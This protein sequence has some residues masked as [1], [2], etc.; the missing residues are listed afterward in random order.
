MDREMGNKMEFKTRNGKQE[1]RNKTELETR[2]GRK[3]ETRKDEKHN[4]L[5]KNEKKKNWKIRGG[6][7][8][9][10]GKN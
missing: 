9:K 7:T 3:W 5:T 8:K 6:N 2:N 4:F 10:T 1:M